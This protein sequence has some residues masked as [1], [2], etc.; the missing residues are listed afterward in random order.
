MDVID[1]SDI[2]DWSDDSEF[3]DIIPA[4]IIGAV[5]ASNAQK[6]PQNTGFPGRE[7]LQELLQSSPKRI[8]DVLRMQ[9]DTFLELCVWLEINTELQSSQKISIQEQ[10]AMFLW[11]LN[12]SSSNRQVKERFQHSGETISR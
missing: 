4:I 6:R 1:W 10:V 11:T 12:Y 8:Y 9:K 2:I 7:Y 3:E 5:Q